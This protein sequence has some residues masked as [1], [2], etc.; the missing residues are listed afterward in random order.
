MAM[1]YGHGDELTLGISELDLKPDETVLKIPKRMQ[2][3]KILVP[4]ICRLYDVSVPFKRDKYYP[5][6]K[7]YAHN[8]YR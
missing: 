4:S 3:Q 5:M 2:R 6:R 7:P 1:D 8:G